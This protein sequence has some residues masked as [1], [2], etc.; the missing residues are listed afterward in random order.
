VLVLML[1]ASG[2]PR[3]QLVQEMASNLGAHARAVMVANTV[4]QVIG[5]AV[6]AALLTRLQSS[7]PA[8][9]LRWRPGDGRPVGLSVLGLFALTPVVM[10]L[11]H[12]NSS[13]PLPQWVK[14]LEEMQMQFIEQ[15]LEGD[16]VGFNL[17]ALA[18]TPA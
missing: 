18:L 13:L 2:V 1:M 4:G 3:D 9:F 11:G 7:R 8:A 15:V 12:L 17:V 10:W 14:V 6:P 16:T 5:L